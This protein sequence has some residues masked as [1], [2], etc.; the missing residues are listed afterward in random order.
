MTPALVTTLIA[1]ISIATGAL[2]WTIRQE[3][4]INALYVI[5]HEREKSEV[6]RQQESNRRHTEMMEWCKRI[7]IKMDDIISNRSRRSND[8]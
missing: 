3:G 6:F 2:V 8:A 5:L 7:E 4:R 1:A